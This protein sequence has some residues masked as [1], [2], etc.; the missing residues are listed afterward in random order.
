M[1]KAAFNMKKTL[2]T[3]NLHSNCKEDKSEVLNLEYRVE[4]C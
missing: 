3:S 2:F 4:R 1:A